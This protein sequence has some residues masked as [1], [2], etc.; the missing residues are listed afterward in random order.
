MSTA[1]APVAPVRRPRIALPGTVGFVLTRLGVGVLTLWVVS[2]LIFFGIEALPG[3][4]ATASLGSSATPELLDQYRADFGLDRPAIERYGDWLGGLLHGDLGR[5][6]PSGT[7]VSDL[8]AGR[9]GYTATLAGITLLVLVPVGIVLGVWSG[10]REASATDRTV[11]AVT[12]VLAAIP[13]FVL[14]AIVLL[15]LAVWWP[16]FPSVS[17]IDTLR[18]LGQQLSVMVLP[19]LTLVCAG[20]AQTSRMVRA[21]MIDVLRQ[22][23]IAMAR[24]K[25]VSER[26]VLWQHALP[27]ALGPT[28]QIVALNVGWLFGGV[29]VVEAVFEFPGVGRALTQAVTTQDV[30][31]V[32][33]LAL[34][35]TAVFLVASIVADIAAAFLNPK[36]RRKL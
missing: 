16:V 1:V 4:A 28:L 24:L 14:A 35:I 13:E 7:P 26:R 31:T 23:Y 10:T 36:I 18:P 20:A 30:A 8:I 29:V 19:A 25:G 32:Q 27:N 12:L 22:P 3:D 15:V 17:I 21:C 11:S 2:L 5:S 34:L 33:S 6:F 9:I